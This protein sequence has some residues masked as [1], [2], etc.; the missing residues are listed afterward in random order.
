M[1]I[2]TSIRFFF[3]ALGVALIII[4]FGILKDIFKKK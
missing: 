1:D 3:A 2:H 4:V